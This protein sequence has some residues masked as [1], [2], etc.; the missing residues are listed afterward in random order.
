M[1][2]CS[3]FFVAKL[4]CSS[5][6]YWL[7]TKHQTKGQWLE[8]QQLQTLAAEHRRLQ[9]TTVPHRPS[10]CGRDG[11]ALTPLVSCT[12]SISALT[13]PLNLLYLAIFQ[14][15]SRFPKSFCSI[16]YQI[17][18]RRTKSQAGSVSA[19]ALHSCLID[20]LSNVDFVQPARISD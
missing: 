11:A 12:F 14:F 20:W 16:S 4:W 7:K 5:S 13:L 15:L 17:S 6:K 2:A 3:G 10:C 1:P 18:C 9:D 19:H 8:S